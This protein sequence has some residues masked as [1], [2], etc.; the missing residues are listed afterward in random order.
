MVCGFDR[1]NKLIYYKDPSVKKGKEKNHIPKTI[2]HQC[3]YILF[4]NTELCW[5]SFNSFETARQ[6]YG[7][8]NDIILI[9]D[10]NLNSNEQMVSNN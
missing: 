1:E 9:Y 8:D 2:K 3:I 7:T 4:F 5:I 10:K 6:A